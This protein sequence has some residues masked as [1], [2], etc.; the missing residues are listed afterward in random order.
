MMDRTQ[1]IEK[2]RA[3]PDQLAAK[4]KGLSAEQLTTPYNTGEW[5]V[6][7]NIHHLADTHMNCFRRFKLILN[8]DDYTFIS[9][10]VD[11]L[12]AMPDG[13]NADIEDSL[14]IL[15]GLHRRWC[16]LMENM[17]EADWSRSGTHP[18]RGAQ[19]LDH[20]LQVYSQHGENHLQQIQ[21]VLDKM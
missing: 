9:L 2:I 16:I 8:T 19:T 6:A 5:T 18:E 14:L 1:M 17:A 11:K 15:R 3:L 21:E 4:V 12:A 13:N 7:Q 10:Y 20:L